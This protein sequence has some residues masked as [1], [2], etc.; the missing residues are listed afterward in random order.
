[1]GSTKYNPVQVVCSG[2]DSKWHSLQQ[3]F[4]TMISN[5]NR[6]VL[7]QSP[8]FIPDSALLSAMEVA[9]LSGV[10]IRVMMTGLPDKKMPFWAAQTYFEELLE[11]GVEFYLYEKGFMHAKVI[12]ADEQIATVGTCNLD[13]RSLHL[14]YE[15]NCLFYEPD[16]IQLLRSQF[17]IDVESCRKI[18]KENLKKLN[19]FKRFRNSLCRIVSPVL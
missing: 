11:A 8:Y 1:M 17:E 3:L 2:P 7:I 18:K 19:I 16:T 15:V 10:K 5:A 9:A 4:F 14:H 6:E 13:V 12:I